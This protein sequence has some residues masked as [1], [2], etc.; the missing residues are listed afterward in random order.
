MSSSTSPVAPPTT[1]APAARLS[2]MA[3]GLLQSE[4]LK[5]S[6]EVRAL[7]ASG[8]TVCN[9]TVG[10]FRPNEFPVPPALADAVVAALRA[11]ETNYPP[12]NGIPELRESIREFYARRARLQLPLE[13][14]LVASGARPVIYATYRVLC[15]PG[16]RVVYPMPSWNNPHYCHLVGA[17]EVPVAC[18]PDEDFLPTRARLQSALRDARLLVL[19]S[20]C[21]PTGTM[22]HPDALAGL[23]DAVLEENARRGAGERPLYLLW[24]QVYWMLTFGNIA[25]AS[26]LVL[27]PELAPY[28]VVVDGISKALAATGLRVGWSVAPRDVTVAMSDLIG[29]IGAWAPRPE[30]VATAHVLRDDAVLDSHLQT[31]TRG[32]V[33]RLHKVHDGISAL[34]ARGHSVE[35]LRPEGAM[36]LSA[37]FAVQG[38]TTSDGRTLDSDDAVRR[39][40][41]ER[42]G[43]AAVPF[44]AFAARED[45][46]WFRLSVGAVSVSE[47]DALLPRLEQALSSL[48]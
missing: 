40:L 32:L 17:R 6:G 31:M 27:R 15:A 11:G 43:L 47:L 22:F 21:N 38:R 24:D 10:D 35:S 44:Q 41:L 7:M 14:I 34:R 19:N 1:S 48:Q 25:H 37:R 29:H 26:P 3:E 45:S 2:P 18:S 46:G 42:A 12:S 16:D 4:I 8:R 28:T 36:Y 20:P 33:E 30:Q 9:L 13:T 39:W 5:I 23:C